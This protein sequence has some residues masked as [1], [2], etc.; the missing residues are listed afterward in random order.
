MS[1]KVVKKLISMDNGKNNVKVYDGKNFLI[2]PNKIS[3]GVL[4][5][6][7][8]DSRIVEFN[9][10]MYTLGKEAD[11]IT[12]KEGKGTPE[13]IVSTLTRVCEFLEPEVVYDIYLSYVES[14]NKYNDKKH[15]DN[16]SNILKKEHTIKINGK[17]Y[18]LNIVEIE[19]VPEGMGYVFLDEDK[20]E[21]RYY[22]GD[23]GGCTFNLVAVD[24]LAL[25]VESSNSFIY[26]M[27]K[28][29]SLLS[30]K[31][32]KKYEEELG[33]FTESDVARYIKQSPS[34]SIRDAINN[35]IE[36]CLEELD[37]EIVK[38]DE[39]LDLHKLIKRGSF[40][41]IGGGSEDLKEYLERHYNCKNVVA[42]DAIKANVLGAYSYLEALYGDD[43]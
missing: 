16:I 9:Q 38:L 26:G 14:I 18:K 29:K 40:K 30:K 42:E 11:V 36:E 34:D 13:H 24:N 2:F 39:S 23:F 7:D 27:N 37:R 4:P 3:H 1:K 21:Q 22:V 10:D 43:E 28:I 20:Y 15:L 19:F 6:T 41:F 8:A 5:T 35:S 33:T 25:D 32:L 12:I 17:N 31:K